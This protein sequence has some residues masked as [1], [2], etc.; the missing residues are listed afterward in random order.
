MFFCS[1][2][3]P[4]GWQGTMVGFLSFAFPVCG[5][6]LPQPAVTATGDHES[7]RRDYRRQYTC[8]CVRA[9]RLIS[10]RRVV[11]Y[12]ATLNFTL[13][14]FPKSERELCVPVYM[15]L[16]T[17]TQREVCILSTI[18]GLDWAVRPHKPGTKFSAR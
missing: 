8:M 4:G 9:C 14:L 7:T 10:P 6:W 15:L 12:M 13:F 17:C 18:S 1:A 3:R 11:A 16:C 2:G 5:G